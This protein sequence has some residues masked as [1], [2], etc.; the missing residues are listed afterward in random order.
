MNEPFPFLY[1]EILLKHSYNFPQNGPNFK[2]TSFVTNGLNKFSRN[3][4][5]NLNCTSHIPPE[6]PRFITLQ[7]NITLK[8]ILRMKLH[9]VIAIVSGTKIT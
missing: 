6:L 4:E 1:C 3:K 9:L 8:N 2:N 5:S 7:D